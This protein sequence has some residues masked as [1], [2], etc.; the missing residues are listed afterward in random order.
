M[1]VRRP[2]PGEAIFCS[3]QPDLR[4]APEVSEWVEATLFDEASQLPIGIMH[5]SRTHQLPLNCRREQ[6]QEPPV[7]RA[8][9]DRITTGSDGQIG[10]RRGSAGGHRLVRRRPGLHHHA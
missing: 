6:Q 1:N 10:P 7:N 5:T 4:P 2:Y 3:W 9:R 8:I